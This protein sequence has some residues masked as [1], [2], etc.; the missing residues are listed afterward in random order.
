[1]RKPEFLIGARLARFQQQLRIDL[2]VGHIDVTA[3]FAFAQTRFHHFVADL[4]AELRPANAI[5]LGEAFEFGHRQTVFVGDALQCFI[6]RA[7]IDLDAGFLRFLDLDQIEHHA[8]KQLFLEHIVG[9]QL[10]TLLFQLRRDCR[11]AVVQVAQRD[12]FVV[13]HRDDAI[14]L[15]HAA[16][17]LRCGELCIELRRGWRKQLGCAHGRGQRRLRL[18]KRGG[19]SKEGNT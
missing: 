5:L 11:Q 12:D 6:E 10:R 2:G 16:G 8:I 14:E 4:F 18:G 3:D 1:M 15:D 7:V 17:F 13:H 9:W 19:G